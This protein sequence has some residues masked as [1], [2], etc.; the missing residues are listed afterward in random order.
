MISNGLVLGLKEIGIM[1]SDPFIDGNNSLPTE[2]YMDLSL[3][4]HSK[5]SLYHHMRP[6]DSE[7]PG[8][9]SAHTTVFPL[10]KRVEVDLKRRERRVRTRWRGV[11][12]QLLFD[13]RKK[14]AGMVVDRFSVRDVAISKC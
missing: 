14:A 10:S 8:F 5:M 3:M 4:M 11:F 1:I 2:R 6:S 12:K 13:E 9:K 7:D